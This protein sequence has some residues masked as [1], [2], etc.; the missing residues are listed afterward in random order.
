VRTIIT[1]DWVRILTKEKK[2]RARGE[3]RGNPRIPLRLPTEYFPPGCADGRLCYTI[4]ICENGVLLCLPQ[5]MD[6]GALLR[7]EIY[8]YFDYE[9]TVF[10]A[11]GEVV[12]VKKLEESDS[13][14]QCALEFIEISPADSENLKRF[15]RKIF[16]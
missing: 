5:E 4:N 3:R 6:V 14:Y 8:Y 9:L 13:E 12:R 16:D 10:E 1:P 7:V 15:L 11:L 2:G